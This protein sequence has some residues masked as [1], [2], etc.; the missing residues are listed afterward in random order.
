MDILSVI[1][2]KNADSPIVL[3]ILQKYTTGPP[4]FCFVCSPSPCRSNKL[5]DWSRGATHMQQPGG[6]GDLSF[7]FHAP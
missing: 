7:L 6:V 1:F 2:G 3:L 5:R 4:V